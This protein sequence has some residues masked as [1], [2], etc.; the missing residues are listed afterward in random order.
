M[1]GARQPSINSKP[2]R[3]V[4]ALRLDNALS[5]PLGLFRMPRTIRHSIM[6]THALGLKYLW[7]DKFCI[8][9]DDFIAKS[10]QLAVMASIYNN[11]YITFA[12]NEGMN[13]DFGIPGKGLGRG[14]GCN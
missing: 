6:L 12:A 4:E 14:L 9:Q 10:H 2:L 1:F 13:G 11:A 3:N 5:L 8:V 7:V